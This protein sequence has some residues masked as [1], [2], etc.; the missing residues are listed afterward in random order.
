MCKKWRPK[1]VQT[2]PQ[3][4]PPLTRIKFLQTPPRLREQFGPILARFWPIF[5]VKNGVPFWPKKR[6]C[7][8]IRNR[9]AATLF[10]PFSPT[11]V[12]DLGPKSLADKVGQVSRFARKP[13][14]GVKFLAEDFTNP[15][16]KPSFLN[17]SV[18]SN[19]FYKPHPDVEKSV[20][21]NRWYKPHP[22]P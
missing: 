21:A 6:C 17:E 15:A 11:K 12:G 19:A 7:S 16:P 13:V 9:S 3:E 10:W 1:P 5:G 20:A 4:T 8:R 22:K 18:C 2:P 14:F